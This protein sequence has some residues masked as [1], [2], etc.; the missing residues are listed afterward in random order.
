MDNGKLGAGKA[1]VMKASIIAGLGVALV[2]ALGGCSN[3]SD[4][5]G[6]TQTKIDVVGI[7]QAVEWASKRQ[8]A[9][10]L[11][12]LDP[13][14]TEKRRAEIQVQAQVEREMWAAAVEVAMKVRP[15]FEIRI[16]SETAAP[17]V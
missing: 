5:N 3:I 17:G 11:E 13:A 9:L 16:V 6:R 1:S 10:Q 14:T 12:F 4:A 8:T 2:L 7:S 15:V